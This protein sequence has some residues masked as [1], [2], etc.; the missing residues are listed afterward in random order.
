VSS[1]KLTIPATTRS[2]RRR[3]YPRISLFIRN[4][5]AQSCRDEEPADL[6][7]SLAGLRKFVGAVGP[8]PIHAI[9]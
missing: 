2:S 4:C 9:V 3:T 1:W 8:R 5:F 6:T 7:F